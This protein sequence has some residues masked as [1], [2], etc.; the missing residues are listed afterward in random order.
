DVF[1]LS[2]R[3]E[4]LGRAM[5]EAM[6]VGKP[7]VVPAIN[8]IPEIVHHRDT[9][10]LYGVGRVDEL[11]ARLNDLLDAPGERTRLGRN[12]RELTRRLFAVETMV[13]QIEGIFD[14]F[15]A[16]SSQRG[17]GVRPAVEGAAVDRPRA[18]QPRELAA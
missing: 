6:L 5:T 17:V 1:A 3:W 15:L 16:S 13:T 18:E 8:G 10:L 4:G 12:A 14:R 2:S 9:G 11:A 7:V